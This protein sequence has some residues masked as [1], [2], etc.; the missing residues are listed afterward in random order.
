MNVACRFN[1]GRQEIKLNFLLTKSYK[2]ICMKKTF[3]FQS[4]I[5]YLIIKVIVRIQFHKAK[6]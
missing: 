2:K 5:N 3:V 4:W 6:A 1:A